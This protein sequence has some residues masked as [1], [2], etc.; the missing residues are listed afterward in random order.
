MKYGYLENVE[1]VDFS[2]PANDETNESFLEALPSGQAEEG[3]K[4]YAGCAKWSRPE[5]KG[6]LY[7]PTAKP[8]E[9]LIHYGRQLN[10]IELNTTRYG[11]KSPAQIIAWREQVPSDFV[12]C[13]K[14]PQSI[15]HYRQLKNT[16]EETMAFIESVRNFDS[17]LGPCFLQLS[18]KF[19]PD[20]ID[21]LTKFLSR[22][23]EGFE[24]VLEL[25]HP[26]WFVEP[27]LN[28]MREIL[29]E[30]KIGWIMTDTPGRRDALH[31]VVTSCT[32]FIR[33]AGCN[34]TNI[35]GRRLDD[36]VNRLDL[37]ERQG[38]NEVYFFIHNIPEAGSPL[39]CHH[40]IQKINGKLKT[41]LKALRLVESQEDLF[42]NEK[43]YVF[44][45]KE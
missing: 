11:I 3:L 42:Q 22:L 24:V 29:R 2:F 43:S 41:S 34:D 45:S 30:K 23:P 21:V 39:L 31:Q 10:G 33:F 37:W 25:R 18:D 26:E 12:F 16:H 35:D 38:V 8:S 4:I 40:L 5:W 7:P 6:V 19:G 27:H 14:F 9:F 44:W 36:W 20:R 32:V 28:R 1:T 17:K 13:P 15:S